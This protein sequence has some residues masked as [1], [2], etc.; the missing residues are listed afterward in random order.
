M[1]KKLRI[2]VFGTWRGNAY[3]KA[4]KFIDDAVVTA[5]CD[6]APNRIEEAKKNIQ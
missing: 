4:V 1:E 3:I 5:L 6:K 2:G